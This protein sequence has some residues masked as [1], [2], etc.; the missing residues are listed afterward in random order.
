MRRMA[1]LYLDF[2]RFK[3]INESY[4][5]IEGDK[6]LMRIADIL[7]N[8]FRA[9]DIISRYGGDEFVV[10][11][12]EPEKD[13]DKILVNRIID[14]ID[15]ENSRNDKAYDLSLSVG[16]AMFEPEFPSSLADLLK[17]AEMLMYENKRTRGFLP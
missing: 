5:K 8:T 10:F 2:D 11:A 14:A 12:V 6:A 9:S 15:E 16:L 1:L 17:K 7:T 13:S 3:N 4:G